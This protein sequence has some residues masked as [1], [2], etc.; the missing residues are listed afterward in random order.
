VARK[1]KDTNEQPPADL[2]IV[3]AELIEPARDQATAKLAE[4]AAL[5]MTVEQNRMY[6]ADIGKAAAKAFDM[7]EGKRTSITGPMNEAKRRVDELFDP[8][9]DTLKALIGACKARLTDWIRE[10]E[11]EKA[12]GLAA[13]EAGSREP[14]VLAAAHT[15]TTMPAG[16]APRKLLHVRIVDHDAI[17][18]Q[19]LQLDEM[20]V[21]GYARSRGGLDCKIPG[22]EF[23]EEID[24]RRTGGG[25]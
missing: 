4:I 9:K 23:Y 19:F 12:R 10:Q 17:P 8:A 5:D 24:V 3:Q 20:L 2:A 16:F 11:A 14:D 1:K 18:R 22:L 6:V 21:L 25:L 7:I 15:T 13:I